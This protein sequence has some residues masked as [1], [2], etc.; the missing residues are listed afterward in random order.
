VGAKQVTQNGT[1][2]PGDRTD[3]L[4]GLTRPFR[5]MKWD[6]HWAGNLC[7]CHEGTIQVCAQAA[8]YEGMTLKQLHDANFFGGNPDTLAGD[9]P[10]TTVDPQFDDLPQYRKVIKVAHHLQAHYSCARLNENGV[11]ELNKTVIDSHSP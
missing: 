11:S 3:F 8:F 6:D 2:Y 4:M 1:V 9:I 5:A 10:S 7:T